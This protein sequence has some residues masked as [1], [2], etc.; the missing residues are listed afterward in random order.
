LNQNETSKPPKKT[1]PGSFSAGGLKYAVSRSLRFGS[2]E[3][4]GVSAGRIERGEDARHEGDTCPY[5]S[6][7]PWQEMPLAVRVVQRPGNNRELCPEGLCSQSAPRC[8]PAAASSHPAQ[9]RGMALILSLCL[10]IPGAA[11]ALSSD[12]DQ[13]IYIEADRAEL[14]KQQGVSVYT[15]NVQLDQG[16][17]HLRG[18]KMTVY[19][20][21]G[22]IDRVIL[23]GEPATYR[24]RPDNK[25]QDV[26][27]EAKHM[28]YDTA[29]DSITLVEDARVWQENGN[30][31]RS[32]RI[33][34][35][36]ADDR[37]QAGSGSGKDR[38]R[39]TL[40]PKSNQDEGDK[41]PA[42]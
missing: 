29:S 8:A 42:P 10:C 27:A 9:L 16:T 19:N 23:V 7:K 22:N 11:R 37:V 13:P 28:E 18:D 3:A 34:Y 6:P 1:I 12:R 30:Q 20:T 31:F 39:I 26:F 2:V 41:K 25:R 14:D 36:I 4:G 17:L 5:R 32:E 38:V 24:Q 21:G 40:Q 15:G 35:H 33:V